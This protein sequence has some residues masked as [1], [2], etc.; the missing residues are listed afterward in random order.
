MKNLLLAASLALH[1]RPVVRDGRLLTDDETPIMHT[2]AVA[3]RKI[4]SIAE[5]RNILP[6]AP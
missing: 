2:A 4:W 6:P 1:G 3:A 5:A